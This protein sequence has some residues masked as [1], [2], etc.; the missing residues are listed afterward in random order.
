MQGVADLVALMRGGMQG[1]ERSA[2]VVGGGRQRGRRGPWFGSRQRL[3][4]LA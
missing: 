4:K 2:K 1:L 3:A